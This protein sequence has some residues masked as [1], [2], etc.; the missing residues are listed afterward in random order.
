MT[1]V[2]LSDDLGNELFSGTEINKL[3]HLALKQ[4]SKILQVFLKC[5]VLVISIQNL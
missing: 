5:N 3:K 1:S 2:L 4:K